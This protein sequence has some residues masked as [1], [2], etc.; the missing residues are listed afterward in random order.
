MGEALYHIGPPVLEKTGEDNLSGEDLGERD[1]EGAYLS[2]A[3]RK[4]ELG[5]GSQI[6][7]KT[8]SDSHRLEMAWD[9]LEV[10]RQ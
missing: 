1:G 2:C 8:R 7:L 3:A 4:T 6:Q 10:F 5:Q 9:T